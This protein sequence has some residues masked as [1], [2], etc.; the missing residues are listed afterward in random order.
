MQL[1]M[2]DCLITEIIDAYMEFRTLGNYAEKTLEVD[3]KACAALLGMGVQGV[4]ELTIRHADRYV[5]S[6]QKEGV[7]PRTINMAMGGMKRM[8]TWAVEREMCEKNPFANWKALRD[9]GVR[10]KKAFSLKEVHELL[11][12]IPQDW[13]TLMLLY[14]CTGLRRSEGLFLTWAEVDLDAGL[15]HLSTGRTKTRTARDVY[16][17]PRMVALLRERQ[18]TSEYVFP[19]TESVKPYDIA[20]PG[21]VM[22][23]AAKRA[24][25]SD[26]GGVSPHRCRH[27]FITLALQADIKS[28]DVG[29]LA[30]HAG[31]I[32]EGTYYH[33]SADHLR[34][35]AA[36]VE[37]LVLGQ[38]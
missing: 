3:S 19:N 6:R 11:E 20:T 17:G 25:W 10:E 29:K 38:E 1:T 22:R 27:T 24:G 15:I 18:R 12:R 21:K 37:A 7:S 2:A 26:L 36:K 8:L 14:L 4:S 13:L 5:A 33:P 35:Q 34:E 31:N 23:T 16:L 32:T 28:Q 30:G 9:H